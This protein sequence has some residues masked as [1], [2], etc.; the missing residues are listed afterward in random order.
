MIRSKCKT[1]DMFRTSIVILTD[2]AQNTSKS[3][4][5][6]IFQCPTKFS[7]NKQFNFMPILPIETVF[8]PLTLLFGPV[9]FHRLTLAARPV[10]QRPAS[11]LWRLARISSASVK[12]SVKSSVLYNA[13]AAHFEKRPNCCWTV[14]VGPNFVGPNWTLCCL[15]L[16]FGWQLET[17]RFCF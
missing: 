5:I 15:V 16:F 4:L 3:N 13:S 11:Q 1:S 12:S 17:L 9:V 7:K 6:A 8:F 14:T 10:F 2:C